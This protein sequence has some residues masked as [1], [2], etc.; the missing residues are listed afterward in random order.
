MNKPE[1]FI[2]LVGHI[3]KR[4]QMFTMGGTFAEVVAYFTGLASAPNACPLSDDVDR[5]FNYFVTARL[6]V[7]SKYWWPG[8]IKIVSTDDAEALL[9]LRDL[10]TEFTEL[11]KTKSFTEIGRDAAKFLAEYVEPE[12]AKVWRQ[13]LAARY[14]S[15]QHEIEP[16]IMPHDKANVLWRGNPTPSG[17]AHQLKEISDGYVVSVI[18]GSL[19]SGHVQLATELGI[20]DAHRVDGSWRIDASSLIEYAASRDA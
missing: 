13:F 6:I 19:E 2:E 9:R 18:S 8:A 3:C 17:V 20:M 16:L 7:P 5:V 4:P 11:R 10:L 1:E 12:P 15:N 14:R